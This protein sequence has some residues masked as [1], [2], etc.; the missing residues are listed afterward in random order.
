MKVSPNIVVQYQDRRLS[1]SGLED[2]FD[3]MSGKYD[4]DFLL[5]SSL[6]DYSYFFLKHFIGCHRKDGQTSIKMVQEAREQEPE[7]KSSKEE[8][9][10]DLS[11]N[12]IIVLLVPNRILCW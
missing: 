11:W 2:I 1:V 6:T 4:S 12:G 8:I 7:E 10:H 9:P 5:S 3:K